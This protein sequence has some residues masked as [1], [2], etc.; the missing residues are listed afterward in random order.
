MMRN[1][2]GLYEISVNKGWRKI[3]NFLRPCVEDEDDSGG[4]SRGTS[5]GNF[6]E[7]YIERFPFGREHL[8]VDRANMRKTV[9]EILRRGYT[10]VEEKW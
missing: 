1:E 9:F 3:P 5:V 10:I 6:H 2:F 8:V 4:L 7:P